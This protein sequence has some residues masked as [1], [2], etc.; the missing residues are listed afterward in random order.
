MSIGLALGITV[1]ERTQSGSVVRMDLS[2]ANCN[3]G[4][5]ANGG[6]LAT[7][8]D[9]AMA[10]ALRASGSQHRR[11]TTVELK[12]NYLRRAVHGPLRAHG[13]VVHRGRQLAVLRADIRDAEGNLVCTGL[14]TFMMT[15]EETGSA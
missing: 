2:A 7:L 6:A 5:N 13:E 11:Q 3:S 15:G 1:E 10:A 4:G 12:V 8:A 9:I 14:G